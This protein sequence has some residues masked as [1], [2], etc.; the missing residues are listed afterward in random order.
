[1]DRTQRG[2]SNKKRRRDVRFSAQNYAEYPPILPARSSQK[3][4]VFCL[5]S[6]TFRISAGIQANKEN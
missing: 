1:M 3:M 6:T 5:I 2:Y 4:L